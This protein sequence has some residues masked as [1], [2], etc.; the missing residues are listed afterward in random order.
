M[1]PSLIGTPRT[2]VSF[3]AVRRKLWI[4][5]PHRSISSTAGV[6]QRRV[7]PQ[8]L[9]LVGVVDEGEH[10]VVDQVPGGLVAGHDQRDEEEVELGVVEALAVDLGL[11]ER[12]HDVVARVGP[13][14]GGHRVAQH[15]DLHGGHAGPGPPRALVVG[16][17]AGADEVV[18]QLEDPRPQ[19]LLEAD[20]LADHLHGDL[21]G[22]L[23]DELDLALLA[24]VVDD[25]RGPA[26]DLLDQHADHPRREALGDELA[27]AVVLGRI[28]VEDREA[29]LGAAPPRPRSG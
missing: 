15:V 8:A 1:S 14:V 23:L 25:D 4:E 29:E 11:H 28:H 27:V 5:L 16:V 20:H 12:G 22:D 18:R 13:A 9:G 21:G 17:V 2:S 7:V 19:L 24:H 3:V 6:P 26:L 10:R